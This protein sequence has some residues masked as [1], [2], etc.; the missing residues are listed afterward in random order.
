EACFQTI[1][2]LREKSANQKSWSISPD[3]SGID[4]AAGKILG[5][6]SERAGLARAVEKSF[7]MESA[8]CEVVH[9]RETQHLGELSRS[10][11]EPRRLSGKQGSN[12][13]GGRTGRQTHAHLPAAAPRSLPLRE[14]AETEQHQKRRSGD[15]LSPEYSRG[16]DCHAGLRADRRRALGRL[17]R[18]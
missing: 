6:R 3:V 15:H 4:P 12:Y 10:T 7:R 5:A 9:R 8:I 11:S 2:G 14:R 13:L 17:W 18:L 1:K 16:R